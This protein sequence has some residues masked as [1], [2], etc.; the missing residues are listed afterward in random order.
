MDITAIVLSLFI[1]RTFALGILLYIAASRAYSFRGIRLK[2]FPVIGF[3]TVFIFQGA[4]IFY[5]TCYTVQVR[6]DSVV[7]LLP[8]II[9]SCLIGALYPLTQ[10][11]QHADD[12]ADG[13][14]T[15]SMVLGKR[16][17]FIFSMILFIS[18]TFLLYIRYL[19]GG[20][21]AY[22]FI[23]LLVMFPVVLYFLFWMRK[24]WH[25]ERMADFTHSMRMNVLA[26]LCTSVVFITLTILKH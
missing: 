24:V 18:A 22:F 3:L 10:V 26:T 15:I 13:V 12:R 7:P 21:T 1:N 6:T 23:Y 17:S 25:D 8:C 4:V 16:G 9:S 2:K 19:H 5:I 14:T 11:Y 20:H